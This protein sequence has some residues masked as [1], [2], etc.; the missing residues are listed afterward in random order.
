MASKGRI[1]RIYP[2]SPMQSGILFH[3]LS[4]EAEVY[5]AQTLFRL[6]GDIDSDILQESVRLLFQR[7]DVLRTVFRIEKTKEPIQLVLK[8]RNFKLHFEDISGWE[9]NRRETYI[10]D[11]KTKDRRKG[12]DVTRDIL[13]R[14]SL[15]KTGHR[16]YVL[17]WSFHHIV[18]DGWCT[19]IVYRD[20]V[21]I[22]RSLSGGRPVELEPA[23]PYVNYIKWL[24]RRDKEEGFLYWKAYLENYK[25][26]ALLPKTGQRSKGMG[27]NHTTYKSVDHQ[28][29]LDEAPGLR[30]NEIARENQVTLNI[31][32]RLLW[33][34]VLQ[35]YNN[36][37]D[38]VFGTVVAGRPPEIDG[39]EN[40]VGLFINTVPVRLNLPGEE[41][42]PRLLSAVQHDAVTSK[43]YEYLPLAEIQSNSELKRKLIDHILVFENF[44]VREAI[45]REGDDNRSTLPFQ[46]EDFKTAEQSNYDFNIIIAPGSRISI[47]FGYN[48]LVF[49][50][51]S[52]KNLERHL[53]EIVAQVTAN[54]RTAIK[55]IDIISKE[56]RHR[57]LVEFNRTAAEYPEEKTVHRLFEE[58]VERTPHNTAVVTADCFLTYRAFNQ[59][60]YRVARGLREKGVRDGSIVGL[61]M[62]NP[63]AMVTGILGVLKA[64]CAYL[65]IDPEYPPGRRDYIAADSNTGILLVDEPITGGD[66]R[67]GT[68]AFPPVPVFSLEDMDVNAP[69]DGAGTPGTGTPSDFVYVI[70]TSGTAGKPKG[71]LVRHKGIVNYTCWRLGAYRYTGKDVTLQ[72]LSYCFDGFGS[73]FYSSLCSGGILVMVPDA[74]KQDYAHINKIVNQKCVTNISLVPGMYE[75]LLDIAEKGD[76][77]TLRF[78]VLA[79]ERARESLLEKSTAACPGIVHIN[80]YGPTEASVT[81]AANID[82]TGEST[83]IIGI[84]ISNTRIYILDGRLDVVP[85]GIPGELC[86]QGAGVSPGY[87]NSPGLSAEKF[88][89]IDD[90][91]PDTGTGPF[92]LYKTGDRARWLPDGTIEY[93][94]R[95]D[96]QVKV[97][98]FRIELREIE[99]QL[100]RHHK[101]NEAVVVEDG[102]HGDT[103]LRCYVVSDGTLDPVGLKEFLSLELPDYMIPAHF[104]QIEKIPLTPNGKV[105]RK[106]LPAPGGHIVEIAAP[107]DET[108]H[109]LAAIWSEVLGIKKDD[110]G[111]DRNFFELGGHSL[112]ATVQAARIHKE[113]DVLVPLEEMFELTTIRQL[114]RY[115]KNEGKQEF[116]EIEA[117]EKKEYYPLSSA[118]KRLY[119][120]HQMISQN[121]SYNTPIVMRFHGKLD[122]ETLEASF[123]KLVKRHEAFRT[124]FRIVNGEPVQ[125]IHDPGDIAFDI[126]VYPPPAGGDEGVPAKIEQFVR[127]FDLSRAPLLR[128]GLVT[129]DEEN[130]VLMIDLHHIVT[131]GTSM[132]II[133]KDITAFYNG[134]ELPGLKIHYKDFSE[135]HN[136]LLLSGKMKKAEAYWIK[137]FEGN[138]PVLNL[139]TDHERP[140]VQTFKGAGMF[141][142]LGTEVTTALKNIALQEEATL[143]MVLIS[144]FFVLLHKLGGQED[145]VIGTPAAGRRHADLE[146]VIGFLVNTLPVR[147]RPQGEKTFTEFLGEVKNKTLMAYANQDYQVDDL[148]A[149]LD[150]PRDTGSQPLFDFMFAFGNLESG[151]GKKTGPE[152]PGLKAE[153]YK[154]ETHVSRFDLGYAGH[155]EDGK[156]YLM[157]EYST[158]IFKEE[159]IERFFDYFKE[160]VD[161]VTADKHTRLK[162]IEI[163]HDL[164]DQEVVVPQTDF[165]F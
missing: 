48:G 89:E 157:C 28:F 32:F 133:K 67:T 50:P 132:T 4:G 59:R 106:A 7:Y 51:V 150:I 117:V 163:S 86:I 72:L 64:G 120:L 149:K 16:S 8:Q 58:Q 10:E 107:R 100:L 66:T 38:I 55:D 114:A 25:Q 159:R 125:V 124:S 42:F 111:I 104:I 129:L 27:D 76:L 15:L 23:T 164:F 60:A 152:G 36:T 95:L 130:R 26:P 88:V 24:E 69:V 161:D 35:K 2:L 56:E 11:F 103:H 14:L 141:F 47:T 19:G 93:L 99:N 49:E 158:I 147:C 140:P 62:R 3:A 73:N 153:S 22:Y 54:P 113:F 146:Q 82:M 31:V 94:G 34:I 12:F 151:G 112:R 46:V 165:A 145:I 122:K 154:F 83:G 70:Y 53:K 13:F 63:S 61:M 80:E 37:D 162:E 135:W 144:L 137:E 57:L 101:V 96:Q 5:F 105:D 136:R 115:I 20:L 6:S 92:T 30:L 123:E 75:A 126:D 109:K 148:V 45:K 85:M 128:A 116:S 142:T 131:D 108:E 143:F 17:V 9:E 78:V 40:M 74:V 44:P 87:L 71:V 21:Q 65:P 43:S 110:I 79:G 102:T 118:Q 119:I 41:S 90:K 138:I 139:P 155:E 77:R 39:I 68:A 121:T 98:G 18:M 156:L 52:I 91:G 160:I 127:P 84:P 29:E 97:R 1:E 33:G 134:E 81:A